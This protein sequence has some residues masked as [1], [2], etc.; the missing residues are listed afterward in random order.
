MLQEKEKTTIRILTALLRVADALDISHL[1]RISRIEIR[2]GTDTVMIGCAGSVP[3]DE[4]Q[5]A[6]AKKG[7]LFEQI[8]KKG[9]EVTWM[10]EP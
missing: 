7:N 2:I 3:A 9:L 10:P 6:V 8:F 1:G 5:S 4:D